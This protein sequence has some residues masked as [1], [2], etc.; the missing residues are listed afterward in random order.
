MLIEGLVE[1]YS[2]SRQLLVVGSRF[3]STNILGDNGQVI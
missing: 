2:Y 1:S 3:R